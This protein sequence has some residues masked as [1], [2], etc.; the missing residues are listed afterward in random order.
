M[1]FFLSKGRMAALI[2]PAAMVL[3]VAGFVALHAS[4]DTSGPMSG[5][6]W[7][8]GASGATAE[9][10]GG[11]G[12]I[13]LN[14]SNTGTCGTVNYG[15]SVDAS[16]IISGYAWSEN[17]GWVSANAADVASCPSAGVCSSYASQASCQS[18]SCSWADAAPSCSGSVLA[19]STWNGN[20]ASCISQ[21][22]CSYNTGNSKCTG[23]HAA[24]TTYGT[25]SP[26]Q[27]NLS[28]VWGVT[29]GTC[30]AVAGMCTPKI[31]SG[32][33]SGWLKALA[34]GTAESGGWDGWISLSGASPAYGPT[35]TGG[36][37][38]GYAWGSDVVGWVDFSTATGACT[39]TTVY[40]CSGTQTIVKTDTSAQCAVTTTN[41]TCVSPAFCSVGSAVCLY[42]PITYIPSGNQ[43]GHL[44][45]SPLIVQKGL[46]TA[47]FWN[48]GNVVSCSVTGSDG[49]T[50]P[51][52]CSGNTCSSGV[53]GT[54]SAAIDQQ[55]TF[56][57]ACTGV[58]GSSI[59]ENVTINI[60]PV[61][62]ER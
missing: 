32:A 59:N 55:T 57:L 19:C 14:C 51:A 10:S 40:T 12:W 13:S 17:V 39:P 26:C 38:T 23:A 60:I 30:S 58:D 31:Q 36:A 6:I 20:Q 4:A 61:F 46:S 34:G 53:G 56:T 33:F 50:F 28:C 16:G 52:G 15:L 21:Q 18:A 44:S 24:C 8:G 45:A 3:C 29:G 48:I 11:I 47:L 9:T 22:G 54:S 41:T 42:P 35:L 5:W 62:Q 2:V 7:S 25:Q 49:E 1:K 43:T 27:T 37:Y